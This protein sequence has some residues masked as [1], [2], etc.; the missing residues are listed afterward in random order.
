MSIFTLLP[1]RPSRRTVSHIPYPPPIL[2]KHHTWYSNDADFFISIHGI[3]FGLHCAYFLQ[4][5]YFQSIMDV[6]KPERPVPKGSQAL[7]PIPFNDLNQLS[8]T[9]FLSF[10]YHPNNFASTKRDWE[11]IR[12]YCIDWYLPEHTVITM[13]KFIKI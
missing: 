2:T 8:F 4:S 11:N 13:Q 12:D 5:C 9:C 10:F 3:L 6:T 1:I 7:Y